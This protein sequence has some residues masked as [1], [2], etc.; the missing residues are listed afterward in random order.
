MK[1]QETVAELAA[2]MAQALVLLKASHG[3]YRDMLAAVG[4][5]VASDGTA[6]V[7]ALC[8]RFNAALTS[9]APRDIEIRRLMARFG[10]TA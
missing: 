3:L 2:D 8:S 7:E 6:D 10:E 4:D 5:S 1:K 9:F